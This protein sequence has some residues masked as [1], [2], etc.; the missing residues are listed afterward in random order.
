MSPSKK[1]SAADAALSADTVVAWLEELAEQHDA[2]SATFR[3]E[4][5]AY[6]KAELK[7]A[8]KVVEAYI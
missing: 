1:T 2:S 8:R 6:L 3:S 7:S 4:M 5:L